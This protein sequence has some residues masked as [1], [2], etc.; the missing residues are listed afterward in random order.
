MFNFYRNNKFDIKK[1]FKKK[2]NTN[3]VSIKNLYVGKKF[4][5]SYFYKFSNYTYF[6]QKKIFYRIKPSKKIFNVFNYFLYRKNKLKK[7]IIIGIFNMLIFKNT[8]LF[9]NIFY[10]YIKWVSIVK[11]KFFI[12]SII[13]LWKDINKRYK[14][15]K[16]NY[17]WYLSFKGKPGL[18]GNSKK[19]KYFYY[20]NPLKSISV[21]KTYW[22]DGKL[23]SSNHGATF[24][25][26]KSISN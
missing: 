14:K 4:E 12:N 7:I 22:V 13:K 19:K 10:F 15:Y 3:L 18:K 17:N 16:Q 26:L 2:L 20:F 21:K 8:I 11:H 9:K 23:S 6:T 25:K 1:K 24:L 5:K